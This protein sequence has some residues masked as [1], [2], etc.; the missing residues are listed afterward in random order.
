MSAELQQV[1][2]A[3][4]DPTRHRIFRY[5]A[6]APGPVGVAELTDHMG[7]NHNAVRQHLAVLKDAQL[8]VEGLEGRQRPGRPRLIYTLHPDTAGTWGTAGPYHFLASILAEALSAGTGPRQAGHDAGRR[9]A[10]R[11]GVDPLDGIEAEMSRR[12]FRPARVTRGSRVDFVLGSCPFEDVAATNHDTVCQL[13]LGLAEGMVE[14]LQGIEV[15]R[16]V[17][18]NPRRGG[19]RLVLRAPVAG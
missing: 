17:A 5:V 2:K 18:K 3:L 8:V 1:A 14:S 15:L 10:L 12:G 16:L 4:G 7:L 9:Q 11:S 6:D 13:H 19:C